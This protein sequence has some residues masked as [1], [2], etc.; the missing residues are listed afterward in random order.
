MTDLFDR[1]RV[2]FVHAH[3][4]DETLA[5]G[6]LIAELAA[7]G[8]EVAVLTA[9]RGEQGEVV[10]GPLAHLA[11]T[12]ELTAHREGEVAAACA[13]LGVRH[14]A[15]LGGP[16]ARAAGLPP[17]RY[18]DSGMAWLDESETVAG[19]G[20]A[21]GP[22]SL[23]SADPAEVAAD[24]AAYARAFGAD[25]IVSYDA[26]GGYGHPDHVALHAPSRAAASEVGVPFREVASVADP[27]DALDTPQHLPL[28]QEAL[29]HYASQL[30]V[31]GAD[32]VHVGGQR[33]PIL[34]RFT[35]RTP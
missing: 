30:T 18:T 10:D 11:G 33:Q 29:R 28:L 13:T 26:H 19:P 23:T 25:A 15:F 6:G 31:D 5:T 8:V 24:I 35:L 2:L 17:R 7:R 21:A 1:S 12:P 32:V 34:T 22:D 16:D 3:P 4:D 27:D 14:H 20:D 9:T